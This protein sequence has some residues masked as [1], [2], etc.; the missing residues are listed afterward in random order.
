[1]NNLNFTTWAEAVKVF[2]RR[3]IKTD[4]NELKLMDCA[5]YL[6]AL[7]RRHFSA[8]TQHHLFDAETDSL[9][10]EMLE[11]FDHPVNLDDTGKVKF[12]LKNAEGFLIVFNASVA[13]FLHGE[14]IDG[15]LNDSGFE[16]LVERLLG[17]CLVPASDA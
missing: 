5:K 10:E 17:N 14:E 2:T 12:S 9:F 11:R 3:V 1:M 15:R 6:Y 16:R 8:E 13:T 4:N 7:Y